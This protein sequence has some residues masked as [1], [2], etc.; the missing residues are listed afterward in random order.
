[1]ILSQI[2]DII[3]SLGSDSLETV[4]G[5]YEGGIYLQQIPDEIAPCI[6][7]LLQEGKF[8]NFLEIGSASGGNVYLFNLFFKFS[9]IVIIDDNH[10]QRHSLRKKVLKAA[11]YREFIGNSHSKEALDFIN[12]FSSIVFPSSTISP[13]S[14]KSAKDNI[15]SKNG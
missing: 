12:E 5:K 4:G 3:D 10:H 14:G 15:S 1:M 6:H 8:I 11:S 7:Y 9:S 13:I 2:R